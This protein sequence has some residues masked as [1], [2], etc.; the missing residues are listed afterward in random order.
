[1]HLLT[2]PFRLIR[3]FLSGQYSQTAAALSFATLLGLVPMIAVA[4]AVLSHLPLADAIAASIRKL[5]MSN[6]LPDKAGGIIANYV[7]QFALK[8]QRLTWI[9]L[10][11]LALTAIVQ[12]LTIEHAFNGIWNVRESRPLAKRVAMHLLALIFGPLIFGG[13]FAITTYLAGASLGLVEEWRSLTATVF[14]LLSFAFI[15]GIFALIYW[16]LPNRPVVWRHALM[17]GLLAAA[18]FSGLH[19]VF[20]GYIVGDSN[21]RAMYGAF[22]AIP[23]FLL[24]LYLS[25]SVILV[26]AMM[27]ADLGGVMPGGR[28]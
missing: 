26:G 19:W 4:A 8:A 23:V 24:W 5:L 9:G 28:R 25:W 18:G 27:T 3:R 12:M 21:Y 7:S 14:K 2:L 15:T 17:G 11:A 1:M 16:K 13:S 20:A 10:G 22:A 6:L